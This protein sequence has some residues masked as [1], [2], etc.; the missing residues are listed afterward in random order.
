MKGRPNVL[1]PE[2]ER[3]WEKVDKSGDCWTWTG[4][5]IKRGYGQFSLTVAEPKVRRSPVKA[6]RYSWQLH[7][8]QIPKEM[9]VLHRCDNP[10]CVRPDHL[11]LGTSLDNIADKV[12]KGRQAK[13]E[14]LRV[15][16]ITEED[17]RDIRR[18]YAAGEYQRVIGEDYGIRQTA[19]SA[20]VLKQ[21]WRHVA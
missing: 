14:G 17:V 15:N 20:I 18:R 2:E 13:G 10:P 9:W 21:T 11:F 12:R 8:G 5:R 6:H 4:H 19:V 3:F 1:R 7:H 16:K